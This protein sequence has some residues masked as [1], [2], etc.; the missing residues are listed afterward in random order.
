MLLS[1]DF[2]AGEGAQESGGLGQWHQVSLAQPL[3]SKFLGRITILLRRGLSRVETGWTSVQA[4]LQ[5]TYKER[6]KDSIAKK[7]RR[8]HAKSLH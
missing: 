2:T 6:K 4:E 1:R 7:E 3:A 5:F 8:N